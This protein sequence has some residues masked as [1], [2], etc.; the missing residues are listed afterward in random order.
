MTHFLGMGRVIIFLFLWFIQ[1]NVCGVDPDQQAQ[2]ESLTPEET[3]PIISY[4]YTLKGLKG[5][6]IP[7]EFKSRSN[8]VRLKK[9]PLYSNFALSR[10]AQDDHEMLQKLLY[11]FG[12]YEATF[13]MTISES[14]E[15][16]TLRQVDFIV[17]LG[18]RY[19]LKSLQFIFDPKVT[20]PAPCPQK[21]NELGL[22]EG[23]VFTAEK[24][25][26]AFDKVKEHLGTC[27]YPFALIKGHEAVLSKTNQWVTLVLTLDPGPYVTFGDIHVKSSGAVNHDY[28]KNRAPFEK[29]EPY[30]QEK[31]DEY[32]DKLS[33]TRLFEKI[34]IRHDRTKIQDNND[35]PL[36]I[37][38]KDGKART[39]SA[40]LKFGT[41][42]GSG[43]KTSWT[44]RNLTG[45]ADRFVAG[46]ELSQ[47]LSIVDFNYYLPDFLKRDQTLGTTLNYKEENTESYNSRGYG[48]SVILEN[49]LQGGRTYF[50]GLSFEST[51]LSQRGEVIH[52][53]AL[54]VPLGF[55]MDTRNDELDPSSGGKLTLSITPEYG[56]LGRLTFITRSQ[57]HGSYHWAID[58]NHQQVLSIWSRIGSLFGGGLDDMPGDRRFF[59]GGG[60]SVRGYGY[61]LAGPLDG[62]GKPLGGKSLFEF[63]IEPRLRFG[64]NWGAVVFLEGALISKTTYPSFA[65]RLLL[66]A[67]LGVRYYTSFGPIRADI[68]IPFRKRR[69]DGGK[70]V[71]R[72]FQFYISIGQ[73]F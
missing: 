31:I 9:R 26:N 41:S 17:T 59:A 4:D 27:G 45:R 7:G 53:D 68:A 43:A 66:G 25:L 49:D 13:D 32:Q 69:Q 20:G 28:I 40:G 64:D 34:S 42:S 18:K 5:T 63:G 23:H 36:D 15:K 58:E 50:Y 8:L 1:G 67:G 29:G 16:E 55:T 71:D 47:I 38:L 51:R 60:G 46:A 19:T 21:L 48:T 10:R 11:A 52:V 56:N 12:Y 57:I 61:Q 3:L 2:K 14:L 44:H 54:G 62:T 6:D 39:L 73:A 70:V 65:D 33:T 22:C 72:A 35:I 30:N 37:E 24:V